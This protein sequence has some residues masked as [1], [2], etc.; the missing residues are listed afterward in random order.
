VAF[1][2]CG[3]REGQVT[4]Y[5]DS[6]Q[7]VGGGTHEIGFREGVAA[8]VTGY[9]QEEGLLSLAE[10]DLT[11]D[12]LGLG[13]TAVVSVKLDQPELLGALHDVLG[14][15]PVRAC[16]AEAVRE[17]L[18]AWLRAEPEQATVVLARLKG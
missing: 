13:L 10:S 6:L 12:Q 9:A 4:S 17:H 14:N 18:A 3:T 15:P 5:V 11:P 8:A 7:T 2:W 16:V 1:R